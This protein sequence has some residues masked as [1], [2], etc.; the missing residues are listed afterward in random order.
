LIDRWCGAK[1][2]RHVICRGAAKNMLSQIALEG[3]ASYKYKA[4]V[5]L[6]ACRRRMFS[7][8]RNEWI[9]SRMDPFTNGSIRMPSPWISSL[10]G[11]LF[12]L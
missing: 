2:T 4:Y 5:Y 3:I 9:R 7:Q 8:N 12:P 6:N 1:K 11:S 10:T